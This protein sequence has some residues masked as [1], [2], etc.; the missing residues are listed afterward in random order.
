[1]I[2]AAVDMCRQYLADI[3]PTN[4]TAAD[5]PTRAQPLHHQTE[6]SSPPRPP[7]PPPPSV[8]RLATRDTE[9]RAV[10]YILGHVDLQPPPPQQQQQNNSLELGQRSMGVTAAVA[11]Q[12][13]KYRHPMFPHALM[14]VLQVR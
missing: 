8:V 13:K 4:I 3:S 14:L 2:D 12:D 1:M 7:V 9:D 10:G 6:S 5:V 11:A